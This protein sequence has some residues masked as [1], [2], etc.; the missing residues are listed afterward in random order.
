MSKIFFSM[1]YQ[2]WDHV[3]LE[4]IGFPATKLKHWL[5]KRRRQNRIALSNQGSPS[6]QKLVSSCDI[7][8]PLSDYYEK[9]M[10]HGQEISAIQTD[11][12]ISQR[13]SIIIKLKVPKKDQAADK[14]IFAHA[15]SSIQGCILNSNHDHNEEAEDACVP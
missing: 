8:P 14:S 10:E 1:V 9:E 13:N 11:D 12:D 7:P 2:C 5:L 15:S 4:S 6:L 3:Y